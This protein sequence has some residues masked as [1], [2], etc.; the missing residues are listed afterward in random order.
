MRTSASWAK[1]DSPTSSAAGAKTTYIGI[2]RQKYEG[3]SNNDIE[4]DEDPA[5]SIADG[6][7]W[8]AAWVWVTQEEVEL[9]RRTRGSIAKIKTRPARF[10][11]RGELHS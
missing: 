7:A 1:A 5:V 10:Q 6:G 9:H 4:I 11:D 2:A 3:A 8:V